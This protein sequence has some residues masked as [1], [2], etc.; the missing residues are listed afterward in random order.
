MKLASMQPYFL[1]Y[2]GYFS[3]I[4]AS[5]KFIIFDIV[6]YIHHGWINRNRILKPQVGWQYI[7]VPLVTH[8][9]HALIKD[10]TIKNEIE[11]DER[12]IRQLSHYKKRAQ[13][14][15]ETVD[16]LRNSFAKKPDHITE[17]NIILLEDICKYLGLDFNYDVA[18]KMDIHFPEIINPGQWGKEMCINVGADTFINPIDRKNLFDQDQY[19]NAGI[20]LI[21]LKPY[22]PEYPQKS[23]D[24]EKRLSIIDVMM[25]NSPDEINLMLDKYS[26]YEAT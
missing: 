2:L 13:Y 4:K 14:Y 17:L 15:N 10:I 18:S 12:I 6:Q 22:M 3:L 5:N 23:S 26:L 24:F 19:V 20:N 25:F 1:P 7:V 16:I 11:W 8:S 21:F 9:S